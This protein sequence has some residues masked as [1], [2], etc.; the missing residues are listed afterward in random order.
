MGRL[1]FRALTASHSMSSDLTGCQLM[2]HGPMNTR[3]THRTRFLPQMA[4]QTMA[5]MAA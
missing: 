4:R 3:P 1:S 2:G 5:A